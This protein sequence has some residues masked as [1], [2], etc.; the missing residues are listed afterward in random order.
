MCMKDSFPEWI[1]HVEIVKNN[2]KDQHVM[3]AKSVPK[4]E[5]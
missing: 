4:F 3:V 2:H 5:Y 1:V